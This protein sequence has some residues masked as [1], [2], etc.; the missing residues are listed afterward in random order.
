MPYNLKMR[1]TADVIFKFLQLLKF[2]W[3]FQQDVF[4]QIKVALISSQ[5][6]SKIEYNK[7][8]H[9]I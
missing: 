5:S 7:R 9:F 6:K 4:F 3:P 2:W 8:K 1:I